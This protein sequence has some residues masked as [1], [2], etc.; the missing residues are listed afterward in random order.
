MWRNES[1]AWGMEEETTALHHRAYSSIQRLI[2]AEENDTAKKTHWHKKGTISCW[3]GAVLHV[4]SFLSYLVFF[5]SYCTDYPIAHSSE[6]KRLSTNSLD[7]CYASGWYLIF[8]L[9]S[10]ISLT[11]FPKIVQAFAYLQCD[12]SGVWINTLCSVYRWASLICC[13]DETKSAICTFSTY[14]AMMFKF[15]HYYFLCGLVC[16][17]SASVM[18]VYLE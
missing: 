8:F 15:E 11:P 16:I 14:K 2:Q 18:Y 12:Y 10:L 9:L 7:T 6:W 4:S 13:C 1:S 5:F 3:D 17:L